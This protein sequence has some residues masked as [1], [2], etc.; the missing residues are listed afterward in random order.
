MPGPT[1]AVFR[2][3]L[4]RPPSLPQVQLLSATPVPPLQ[5]HLCGAKPRAQLLAQRRRSERRAASCQEDAA[6]AGRVP[7]HVL[8]RASAF[9]A[10]ATCML[11]LCVRRQIGVRGDSKL[12]LVYL[13]QLLIASPIMWS[14]WNA[15]V[16]IDQHHA[17][18]KRA[19]FISTWWV[20]PAS[21]ATAVASTL[22]QWVHKALGT[23]F[24]AGLEQ[25]LLGDRGSK[26]RWAAIG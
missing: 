12:G 11:T 6:Q 3:T 18:V 20:T 8:H 5:S 7:H 24:P 2:P 10:S 15:C 21:I 17:W 14:C 16:D 19:A 1:H 4:R 9:L 23:P 25:A 26:E 22:A 13:A